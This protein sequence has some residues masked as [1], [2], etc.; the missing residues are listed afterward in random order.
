MGF[1]GISQIS[2]SKTIVSAIG[3]AVNRTEEF[4]SS[5]AGV[6]LM[7]VQ[8]RLVVLQM[9]DKNLVLHSD[10]STDIENISTNLT[11]QSFHV[12]IGIAVENAAAKLCLFLFVDDDLSE[13]L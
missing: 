1:L 4:K 12:L 3:M 7:F 2:V 11:P 9:F 5:F 13:G 8:L 10:E 6:L